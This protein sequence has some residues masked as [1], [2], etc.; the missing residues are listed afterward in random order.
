M[1]KPG[2][3][4]PDGRGAKAAPAGDGI[5]KA[6]VPAGQVLDVTL[7]MRKPSGFAVITSSW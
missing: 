7:L 1:R 4:G 2:I 5:G 6:G 3:P